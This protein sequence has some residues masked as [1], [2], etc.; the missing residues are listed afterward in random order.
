MTAPQEDGGDYQLAPLLASAKQLGWVID[1]GGKRKGLGLFSRPQPIDLL[2]EEQAIEYGQKE[3][4]TNEIPLGPPAF[5]WRFSKESP[6]RF[7]PFREIRFDADR[8]AFVR[9]DRKTF[10]RLS[11]AEKSG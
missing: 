3:F 7:L 9:L 10:H 1:A 5:T 11:A 4:A 6:S 8:T 2:T